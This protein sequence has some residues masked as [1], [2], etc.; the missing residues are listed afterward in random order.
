M[1][2]INHIL[3]SIIGLTTASILVKLLDKLIE[4]MCE[5]HDCRTL[6]EQEDEESANK[7]INDF[8]SSHY[9]PNHFMFPQK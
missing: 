4:K 9:N 2:D 7:N 5:Y 8:I 1:L 6:E 3:E